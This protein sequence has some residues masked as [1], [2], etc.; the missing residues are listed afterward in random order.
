MESDWTAFEQRGVRAAAIACQKIEGIARARRFVEA[1]RYPF[2]ILFDETR[3]TSMDYGVFH[4]LDIDAYR[5]ARP[6][7]F[8]LDRAGTIRWIAV[9]PGQTARPAN[10]ALI[11]AVDR[12]ARY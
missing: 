7:V 6:A 8:V 4:A 10:S 3:R 12:A 1:Q 2:P 5:I 9:S 11:D